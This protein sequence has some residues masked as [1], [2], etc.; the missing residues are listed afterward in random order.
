[1]LSIIDF[2]FC[3]I[4]AVFVTCHSQIE[5]DTLKAQLNKVKVK[6]GIL[7]EDKDTCEAKSR[8]LKV[9]CEVLY[10]AILRGLIIVILWDN[11]IIDRY[12][13]IH[14]RKSYTIA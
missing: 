8:G 2:A 14:I 13:T 9:W 6:L 10:S 12:W 7:E 4:L 5:I 3:I 11:W 1:M